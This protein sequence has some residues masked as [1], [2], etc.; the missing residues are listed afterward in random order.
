MTE[1]NFK[2]TFNNSEK[3]IHFSLSDLVFSMGSQC[4]EDISL[5]KAVGDDLAFLH[6]NWEISRI[7]FVS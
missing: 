5:S 7:E 3:V 1:I 2:A 6:D 4:A